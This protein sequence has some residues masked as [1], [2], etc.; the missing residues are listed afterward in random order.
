MRES[1]G[2]GCGLKPSS[3]LYYD[4][5]SLLAIGEGIKTLFSFAICIAVFAVSP[6]EG[7]WIETYDC[8]ADCLPP[9]LDGV[10]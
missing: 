6:R 2:H 1:L 3:L 9:S 4:T 5:M 7:E 8:M 10:D